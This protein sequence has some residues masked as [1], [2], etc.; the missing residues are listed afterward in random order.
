MLALICV[1]T[2]LRR[3]MPVSALGIGLIPFAID[4]ALGP[5]VP[6]WLIHS[7]LIYAGGLYAAPARARFLVGVCGTVS[8]ALTM[9]ALLLGDWRVAV[10]TIAAL[11]AFVA[12]P[13]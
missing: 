10:V 9:L 7:D 2:F 1:A 3:G 5:T 4:F 11:F 6:V 12:T 13:L 8:A